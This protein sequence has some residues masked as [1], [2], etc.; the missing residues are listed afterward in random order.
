MTELLLVW[1]AQPMTTS[2]ISQGVT[3]PQ[4]KSPRISANLACVVA[5]HLLHDASEQR[6]L[7]TEPMW[8]R[9]FLTKLRERGLPAAIRV[10]APEP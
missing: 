1:R 9:T 5:P 6:M 8:R 7:S 3:H 4:S 10:A 2:F